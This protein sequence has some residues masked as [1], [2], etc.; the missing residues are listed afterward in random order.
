MS[1]GNDILW[2]PP[3]P[4]RVSPI[5]AVIYAFVLSLA[6]HAA[7][8][9]MKKATVPYH[10]TMRGYCYASAPNV[11]GI[12]PIVGPYIGMIWSIVTQILMVKDRHRCSGG[13]AAI[14]VLWVLALV[15]C[16]GGVAALAMMGIA[17]SNR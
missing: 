17:M 8:I 7:L 1:H 3:C 14:A 16:C 6:F 15:V 12:V 10:Q 2:I 11:I 4:E 5:L 13:T 9:V